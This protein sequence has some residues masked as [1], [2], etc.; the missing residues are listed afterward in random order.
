MVPKERSE[1]MLKV[2]NTLTGEKEKFETVEAGKVK[3]YVCG[4]TVQNYSHIG[5]IRSAINYDV[6]RRFLEYL[7]YEVDYISNFTDIN[8]SKKS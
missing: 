2:Y 7:G 4:L 6:I 1:E 8:E 5:H 3:M